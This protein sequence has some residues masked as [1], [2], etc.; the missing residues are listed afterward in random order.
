MSYP[1]GRV[2]THLNINYRIRVAHTSVAAQPPPTRFDRYER[3]N[4]NDGT[5]QPQIIYAVGDRVL[6]NGQLFR[7]LSVFQALAG[8]TPAANP[9]LWDALPNTACGQL[10]EFCADNTGNPTGASCL[11]TGQAN[12][13][14]TCLTQLN[15]CLPVCEFVHA[16]AVRGPLQQPDH[17]HRAGRR[18][19]PVRP[20]RDGRDLPPD[21]LRDLL[22]QQQRLRQP[23]A[24]DRQRQ[25]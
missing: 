3:V 25:G 18:Q 19:L 13:E 10:A 23:A 24:A 20:A 22:G 7:A 16:D 17:L 9:A 5:W 4:N 2:V 14:A 12:V 6:F 21:D 8:Q 15:T 11:A 1:V